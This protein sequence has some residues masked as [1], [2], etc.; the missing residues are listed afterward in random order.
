ML[1][2][3]RKSINAI[4]FERVTSPL[5]GTLTISWIVWNWKIIYLTFFISESKVKGNK[6][7]YIIENYSDI[8]L[9]VTYPLI[10]TLVLITLIPFLSNGAFWLYLKFN[11][12]K[13][14]KKNEVEKKQLLSFEKSLAIRKELKDKEIEFEKLLSDKEE[15]IELLNIEI[16]ELQKKPQETENPF[17]Q[18]IDQ[19]KITFEYEELKKN[20]KAFRFF[21]QIGKSITSQVYLPKSIPEEVINYY[22][23]NDLITRDSSGSHDFTSNGKKLYKKYFNQNFNN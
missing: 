9:L 7:D 21:D 23:I 3:L 13:I 15:E 12:W 6:I 20:K 14:D 5:F 16:K 18:Q 22:L 2:D 17:N 8:H 19:N 11:R 4:L 1:S 10:S